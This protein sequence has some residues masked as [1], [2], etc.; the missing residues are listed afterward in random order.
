MF[1]IERFAICVGPQSF[2]KRFFAFSNAIHEETILQPSQNFTVLRKEGAKSL[3]IA[4]LGNPNV[5]KSSIVNRLIA[6]SV[7][8]TSSKVHTT[9][10]KTHAIYTEN[11]VQLIFVDTPGLVTSKELNK[12]NLKDSYK[13]D[14]EKSI[15]EADVIG[16]VQDTSNIFTRNEISRNVINLLNEQNVKVPKI[17]IWNKIDTLKNKKILLELTRKIKKQQNVPK[18]DDVFM[19]SALTGDGIQDLRN[20]FI[21][22]AKLNDWTY[23]RDAYTDQTSEKLV[24]ETVRAKLLDGLPQEVPYQLKV[25]LEHFT[26]RPDGSIDAYVITWCRA[27]RI[28]KLLLKNNAQKIKT[29]AI[30]A[31][32]ELRN[33]FRTTVF[34]KINVR[35]QMREV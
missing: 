11:D 5:G 9:E 19:I 34:V 21:D 27:N 28:A 25:Q 22:S 20:Y 8:P 16:I 12:Y 31:E 4:M 29:I 2:F 6:R 30:L 17:L 33:A 7:C 1:K 26:V 10:H 3:K 32:E 13:V 18:F 35:V 24:E 23:E 15:H 14:L